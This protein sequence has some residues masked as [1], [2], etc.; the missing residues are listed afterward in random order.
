MNIKKITTADIEITYG[1]LT[2][3][4]MLRYFRLSEELTQIELA[5]LLRISKQSVNDIEFGRK[6]PSI[7]RAITI[8]K[9]VQILPA[10]AV[11]LVLQDQVNREHLN[12]K[13]KVSDEA[14]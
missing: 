10:L 1:P 11:E 9:R 3:G 6:I 14:A 12:L 8:A 7:K 4:N 13:V 2:F 5:K